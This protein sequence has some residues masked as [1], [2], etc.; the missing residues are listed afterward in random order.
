MIYMFMID[1]VRFDIVINIWTRNH[2]AIF[3]LVPLSYMVNFLVI[4]LKQLKF[5][6]Y[7]WKKMD[8]GKCMV[9]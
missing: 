5:Y 6:M 3:V 8:T 9:I 2:T 4:F 1:N 7:V